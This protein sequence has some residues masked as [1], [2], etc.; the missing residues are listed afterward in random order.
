M[1]HGQGQG[2]VILLSLDD[3]VLLILDYIPAARR[4]ASGVMIDVADGSILPEVLN[5]AMAVDD[6]AE[7]LNAARSSSSAKAAVQDVQ[8]PQHQQFFLQ[9]GEFFEQTKRQEKM[10]LDLAI[11]QGRCNY[12]G[13]EHHK[14]TMDD[15]KEIMWW[16]PRNHG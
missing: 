10:F 12:D 15:L 7:A 16:L 4:A 9:Q 2:E 11:L 3:M 13:G 8:Q 14:A 1:R 6:T 5:N